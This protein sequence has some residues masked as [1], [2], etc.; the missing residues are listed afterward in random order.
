M[1]AISTLF[2]AAGTILLASPGS[3]ANTEPQPAPAESQNAPVAADLDPKKLF[4]KNCT[5]CHAGFGMEL[6]KGP[7][8]AG[9]MLSAKGVYERISNGKSGAMPAYKKLLSEAEIQALTD[10]IKALPAN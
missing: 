7:K 8:L 1:K 2:L 9:T 4:A 5:W 10:Y 3:K 6:G